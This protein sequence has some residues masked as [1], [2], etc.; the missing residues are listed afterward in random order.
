MRWVF[1]GVLF[2]GYMIKEKQKRRTDKSILPL[3][4][5]LLFIF[6]LMAGQPIIEALRVTHLRKVCTKSTSGVIEQIDY[7]W[8]KTSLSMPVRHMEY[9]I[10]YAYTTPEGSIVSSP[11]RGRL[12]DFTHTLF[13]PGWEKGDAYT[14]QV[15]GSGSERKYQVGDQVKVF[16]NP[17]NPRECIS[18]IDP[19]NAGADGGKF[20]GIV[21]CLL[22]LFVPGTLIGMWV[23]SL[24][25]R[26]PG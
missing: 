22:I 6:F 19:V 23:Q 8:V 26:K 3:T 25:S 16:Y 10:T 15:P 13:R 20:L 1:Q 9:R 17:A 4:G 2:R 14:C 18:G 12:Y 7:T 21:I 5:I 24:H 11:S